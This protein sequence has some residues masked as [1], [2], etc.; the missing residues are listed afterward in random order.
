[1]KIVSRE[2]ASKVCE[3]WKEMLKT[4]RHHNHKIVD[5]NGVLRWKENEDVRVLF[6]SNAPISLNS[7]WDLFYAMGLDK[8]SEFIRDFYR[9]MGYSLGCF[10]E[11]FYWEVNNEIANEYNPMLEYRE[12]RINEILK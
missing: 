6:G 11:I 3:E 1:M 9:N 5:V 7:L 12:K 4:E 8:N 2:E 10:W